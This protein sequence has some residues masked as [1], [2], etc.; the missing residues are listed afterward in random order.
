M[1]ATVFLTVSVEFG[2]GDHIEDLL[3]H[4]PQ[5]IIVN[6]LYEW[7][8]NTCII[9]GIALGKLAIIAFILQIEG[10]SSK[11]GRNRVLY[12]F[13]ALNIVVNIIII[14]IVWVYCTP[15]ANLWDDSL[16]GNCGGRMRNQLYGYLQGS[17]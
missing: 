8:F 17:K 16:S 7:L 10:A 15:S 5:S 6:Q 1:L 2:L 11:S 13:A 9:I 3:N 4:S 14:P 12:I